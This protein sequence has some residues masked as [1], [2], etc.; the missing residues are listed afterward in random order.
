M[1][2]SIHCENIYHV[3]GKGELELYQGRN[4]ILYNRLVSEKCIPSEQLGEK[5][6]MLHPTDVNLREE[7]EHE[8]H[9]RLIAKLV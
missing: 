5:R 1:V 2:I 6:A 7:V 3:L 8:L 9:E 4:R